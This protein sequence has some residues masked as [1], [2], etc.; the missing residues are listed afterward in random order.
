MDNIIA[1]KFNF[2]LD[3]KLVKA[4]KDKSFMCYNTD[5]IE[6]LIDIVEK[7]D[8]K[9]TNS[10]GDI[11]KEYHEYL[12]SDVRYWIADN[13]YGVTIYVLPIGRNADY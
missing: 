5:D 12:V 4:L 3:T 13:S 8:K 9:K 6:L 7:N 1:K 11:L 2:Q 10:K